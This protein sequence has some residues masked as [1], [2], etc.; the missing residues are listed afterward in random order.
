MNA[1]WNGI[2]AICNLH[3]C[4]G[5]VLASVG[6]E[7]DRFV[8]T[9]LKQSEDSGTHGKILVG[10][11]GT[12]AYILTHG[13]EGRPGHGGTRDLPIYCPDEEACTA[14]GEFGWTPL[15]ER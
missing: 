4:H 2:W 14:V 13:N 6:A 10:P 9:L 15:E 3:E 11:R 12:F 8:A 5:D 7:Q 1:C